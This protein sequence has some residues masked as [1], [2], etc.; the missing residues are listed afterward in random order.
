MDKITIAVTRD[1]AERLKHLGKYG[2]T[3]ET[4]IRRVLDEY[5]KISKESLVHG[6]LFSGA[7]PLIISKI[8]LKI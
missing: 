3:M 6:F 1:T 4:I 5:E 8:A 7:L 2:D